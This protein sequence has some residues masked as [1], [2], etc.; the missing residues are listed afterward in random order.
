MEKTD[1]LYEKLINDIEEMFAGIRVT[2]EIQEGP[3][4]S[5]NITVIN[6]ENQCG[7]TI[8]FGDDFGDNVT[9]FHCYLL[10]EHKGPHMEVGVLY[11][12][13]YILFWEDEK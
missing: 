12:K 1:D 4:Q 11:G 6:E 3:V 8:E 5:E 13:K 2:N 7:A 10:K 9:T